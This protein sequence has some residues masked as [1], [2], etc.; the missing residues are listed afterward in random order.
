MKRFSLRIS[1]IVAAMLM[2]FAIGCEKDDVSP[3]TTQSTQV[4]NTNSR[5][6]TVTNRGDTTR[7]GGTAYDC[8]TIMMNFGDV[9][10]DSLGNSGTIDRNCNCN[11]SG[12]GTT[13]DCPRIMANY[14]DACR[15]SLGNSGTIDRILPLSEN[16]EALNKVNLKSMMEDT[17]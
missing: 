12:S 11:T 6:T 2:V 14:G 15:D 1:L 9:C 17:D 5:D 16:I 3:E 10:R 4:T 13:Y 7:N 8:P